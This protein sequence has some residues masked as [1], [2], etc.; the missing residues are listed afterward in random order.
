MLGHTYGDMQGIGV[1]LLATPA[2]RLFAIVYLLLVVKMM[3]VG[4]ATTALRLRRKV[5][6]TPEDYA[7]NRAN[8]PPVPDEDIE[9]IRRA[10]RNDLENILPFFAVGLFYALTG[11]SLL[12][13]RIYFIGFL[14]ARVLHSVFYLQSRQPHRTIAFGAGVTLMSLMLVTTL[15]RLLS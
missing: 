7:L 1:L 13:A 8:P 4:F 6:A 2:V 15:V 5:F 12:A 3:V 10:H 14:L 9:R 11:P